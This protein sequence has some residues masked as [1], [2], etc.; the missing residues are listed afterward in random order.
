MWKIKV[1]FKKMLEI[2]KDHSFHISENRIIMIHT[3]VFQDLVR[4][5]KEMI[6]VIVVS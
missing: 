5:A 2:L 6:S 3:E 4:R 1:F